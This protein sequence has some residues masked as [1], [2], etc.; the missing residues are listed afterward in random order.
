MDVTQM[1]YFKIIAETNSLTKAAEMLHISQPAMSAMLKKFEEELNAELFHRSPNRIHLNEAGE[2]A[3]IHINNI[4]RNIEQMKT[5]VQ[6]AAQKNLTLSIAFPDR[7]IQW[8][9]VPRFSL[10][11]P[12]IAVNAELY[13]GDEA[14]RLLTER[15]YDLVITPR[16]ISAPHIQCVPFLP[17]RVYLSVPSSGSL[18]GLKSISLK[19]IPAQPLL[20]PLIGGYFVT[21]I[22]KIIT[23]NHLPVTLMKNDFGIIQHLIRTT[24]FLATI[25]ELS[26]DLRNDGSHRTLIPLDDPELNVTY[27]ASYLRGNKEKVQKVF[28]WK[29]ECL[30]AET[31]P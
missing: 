5:D 13:E 28:E 24:N 25:S 26:A 19:D 17:D 20:H 1:Q 7:G 18:A 14:E 29:K 10:A 15:T 3:L 21:Q 23:E 4:L 30:P 2:I 11:C 6:S 22:E 27:H 9:F 31:L 16:K 12:E 8:F